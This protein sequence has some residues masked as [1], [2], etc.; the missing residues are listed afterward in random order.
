MKQIEKLLEHSSRYIRNS[1]ESQNLTFRHKPT[2]NLF[3]IYSSYIKPTHVKEVHIQA[4]QVLKYMIGNCG[5]LTNLIHIYLQLYD[6]NLD[7]NYYTVVLRPGQHELLLVHDNKIFHNIL[8]CS[9]NTIF[10]EIGTYE[11]LLKN[12]N[13]MFGDSEFYI[14]DTWL[15]KTVKLNK[16]GLDQ[17]VSFALHHYKEEAQIYMR[18][19]YKTTILAGS[20]ASISVNKSLNESLKNITNVN[21]FFENIYNDYCMV[22][23]LNYRKYFL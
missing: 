23:K 4:E 13:H 6:F 1:I 14:V 19:F 12:I 16:N 22:S 17:L 7:H 8:M 21:N 9:A 5:D 2:F 3:E 11:D 10:I 18:N 15:G 20:P